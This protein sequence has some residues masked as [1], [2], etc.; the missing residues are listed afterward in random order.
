MYTL[1][2]KY[3]DTLS[4]SQV[5]K[6]LQ[7]LPVLLHQ[8]TLYLFLDINGGFYIYFQNCDLYRGI[9]RNVAVRCRT[10]VGHNF[11][12]NNTNSLSLTSAIFLYVFIQQLLSRISCHTV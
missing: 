10:T 5:N 4:S 1:P 11:E 6:E 9:L 3:R 2:V 7:V 8:I 12:L